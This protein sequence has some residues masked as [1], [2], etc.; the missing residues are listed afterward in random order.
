MGSKR[1]WQLCSKCKRLFLPC[2][3]ECYGED[4][5]IL[6]IGLPQIDAMLSYWTLPMTQC[7]PW[8]H[9]TQLIDDSL[10]DSTLSRKLPIWRTHTHLIIRTKFDTPSFTTMKFHPFWKDLPMVLHTSHL[11]H[12]PK[13][14]TRYLRTDLGTQP[15]LSFSNLLTMSFLFLPNSRPLFC[16]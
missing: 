6:Y 11:Q 14:N 7:F 2:T 3:K 16:Q 13:D 8:T 15:H 1:T 5:A 9:N 10:L 12:K 4:L